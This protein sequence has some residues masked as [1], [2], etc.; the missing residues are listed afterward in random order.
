MCVLNTYCRR[1]APSPPKRRTK[2]A[3]DQGRAPSMSYDQL[4]MRPAALLGFRMQSLQNLD[5]SRA[6]TPQRSPRISAPLQDIDVEALFSQTPPPVI[7]LPPQAIVPA[8]SV[9]LVAMQEA[10]ADDEDD[11]DSDVEPILVPLEAK[12]DI[13]PPLAVSEVMRDM[14]ST[15]RVAADA[16]GDAKQV[17]VAV[18]AR[19]ETTDGQEV[20]LACTKHTG[21]DPTNP[22]SMKVLKDMKFLEKSVRGQPGYLKVFSLAFSKS[23]PENIKGMDIVKSLT[24]DASDKESAKSRA[25]G[26]LPKFYMKSGQTKN[27]QKSSKTPAFLGE[28]AAEMDGVEFTLHI[29]RDNSKGGTICIHSS[30]VTNQIKNNTVLRLLLDQNRVIDMTK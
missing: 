6:S 19:G 24:G 18:N 17:L 20:L 9:D 3:N 29:C 4:T 28:R 21:F 8:A 7:N 26:V 5:K 11:K 15:C 2:P 30:G 16:V 12:E 13:P 23:R 10:A 22:A 27:T 25:A 14:K 1:I